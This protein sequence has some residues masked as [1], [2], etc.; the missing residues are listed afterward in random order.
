MKLRFVKPRARRGEFT[1][2][3]LKVY[4]RGNLNLT[5][6]LLEVLGLDYEG[7]EVIAE[8]NPVKGVVVLRPLP[9]LKGTSS[10]SLK[11]FDGEEAY[12]LRGAFR[13]AEDFL[14]DLG[15][16][17]KRL[18]PSLNPEV[19]TS[20]EEK[21]VFLRLS[22]S[23]E[24]VLYYRESLSSPKGVI[25]FTGNESEDLTLVEAPRFDGSELAYLA[26]KLYPLLEESLRQERKTYG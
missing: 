22:P 2:E 19:G 24:P 23:E 11:D 18:F 26:L 1:L 16:G 4:K 14:R 25:L 12:V 3:R 9:P 7:G 20:E 17:L 10:V 6:R 13:E 15:E 21:A 8:A 5:K